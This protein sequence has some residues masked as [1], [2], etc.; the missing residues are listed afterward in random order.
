LIGSANQAKNGP[1]SGIGSAKNNSIGKLFSTTGPETIFEPKYTFKEV[2]EDVNAVCW[3]AESATE[4]LAATD[5]SL[6]LF[7]TRATWMVKDFIEDSHN[8]R[9]HGI[10]FDPFDKNRFASFSDDKIKIYDLRFTKKPQ[11]VLE[12]EKIWGFDWSHYRSGLL[13]SYNQ[14]SD[15]VKF[16]DLNNHESEDARIILL[17]QKRL[18]DSNI[19]PQ[20]SLAVKAQN[21]ENMNS[22]NQN[23]LLSLYTVSKE[24]CNGT[25][26][27]NLGDVA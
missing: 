1:V 13:A 2:K 9:V 22:L 27:V 18:G 23:D 8:K 17:E 19:A 15:L 14:N 21:G 24:T 4:L 10:Q 5:E 26:R 11:Y 7:D 6:M 3:L 16:W 25:I 20:A 12:D